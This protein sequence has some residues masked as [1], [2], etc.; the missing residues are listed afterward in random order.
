MSLGGNHHLGAWC[1]PPVYPCSLSLLSQ[2]LYAYGVYAP[3]SLLAVSE[4]NQLNLLP[5]YFS[6]LVLGL[7]SPDYSSPP[8]L[9]AFRLVRDG[10]AYPRTVIPDPLTVPPVLIGVSLS[11]M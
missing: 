6:A 11:L 9:P 2:L 10:L 1:V 3:G 7:G 4:L 5:S 8:L